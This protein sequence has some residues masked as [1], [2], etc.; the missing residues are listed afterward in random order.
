MIQLDS[1][2]IPLRFLADS[3]RRKRIC[4]PVPNHSA[5]EPF[6]ISF[7]KDTKKILSTQIFPLCGAGKLLNKALYKGAGEQNICNRKGLGKEGS[8]LLVTKSCNT[9]PD[10]SD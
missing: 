3:N 9:A 5:K 6:L 1:C 4:S 7:C 8:N 10:T 2:P